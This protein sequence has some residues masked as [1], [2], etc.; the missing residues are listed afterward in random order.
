MTRKNSTA[1]SPKS[2]SFLVAD[3][4]PLIALDCIGRVELPRSIAEQILV[5]EEVLKECTVDKA[6][7]GA[8]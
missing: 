4:G 7:P 2:S 8:A 3:A 6:S 1:N 5:P